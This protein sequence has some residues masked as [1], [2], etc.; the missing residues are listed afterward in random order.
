MTGKWKP[1]DYADKFTDAIHALAAQRVKAGK[2]E[3]VTSLEGDAAAP[4]SNVVDLTELL[5]KSL[6][7]RKTRSEPTARALPRPAPPA[8]QEGSAQEARAKP[9]RDAE[10]RREPLTQPDAGWP[11]GCAQGFGLAGLSS[12]AP[13]TGSR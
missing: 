8:R 3:K 9:K 7:S 4:A 10:A 5:K 2:T 12:V 6:E 11:T 1:D 13:V